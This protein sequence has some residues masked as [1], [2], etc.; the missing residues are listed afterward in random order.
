MKL[1]GLILFLGLIALYFLDAAFRLEMLT[2]EM[3]GHIALRFFTGFLILGIGV[4]YEHV[5]RFKSSVFII[6]ALLLGDDIFD[7]YRNVNSFTP[8]VILLSIYMLL[9]GALTGYVTMRYIKKSW[10]RQ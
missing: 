5:I 9:W 7:Y 4:F 2:L 6:L 1:I 3:L 10:S 8:E